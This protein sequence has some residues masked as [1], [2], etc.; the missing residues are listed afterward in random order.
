MELIITPTLTLKAKI[1]PI[2]IWM[3]WKARNFKD[4]EAEFWTEKIAIPLTHNARIILLR[5]GEM[6]FCIKSA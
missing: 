3:D 4:I 5:I 6:N 1:T 2:G